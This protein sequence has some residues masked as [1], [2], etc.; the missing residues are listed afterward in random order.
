M[1]RPTLPHSFPCST[2]GDLG[3]NFRVRDGIGCFPYSID[4]SNKAQFIQVYDLVSILWW[5]DDG[6]TRISTRM[7]FCE[8]AKPIL[9]L[10]Q[11]HL[12]LPIGLPT[13]YFSNKLFPLRIFCLS[14][15]SF[16]AIVSAFWICI[17]LTHLGS[18]VTNHLRHLMIKPHDQ[19]VLVSSMCYHTSTPSLSTS[20]STRGLQEPKFREILF[21]SQFHT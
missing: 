18:S 13:W 1:H 20:W 4:T 6:S 2:I 16:A 7:T 14:Y 15:C 8:R 19:L 17:A 9:T 10:H 11:A 5:T 21:W 12:L 3:L